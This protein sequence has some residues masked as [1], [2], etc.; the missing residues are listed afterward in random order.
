MG[1]GRGSIFGHGCSGGCSGHF[2][3]RGLGLFSR[4]HSCGGG[5]GCNGFTGYSV[6][7]SSWASGCY[8]SSCF[9]GCY[10]GAMVPPTGAVPPA[11]APDPMPGANPPAT[12][13]KAP[14]PGD[15]ATAPT[16]P[17]PK[18][19]DIPRDLP[20]IDPPTGTEISTVNPNQARVIVHLPVDAKL[21]VDQVACPISGPTRAFNTPALTPGA[22]YAYTLTVEMPGGAREDRRITMTAGGTVE[23]EFRGTGI[24]TVQR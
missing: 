6:G 20:K 3:G 14:A 16:Q 24:E 8:G 2:G 15:K 19:P 21:W 18:L 4:H 23:V 10:G 12:G 22:Q 1:S 11:T 13:D 5:Y 7:Y 17:Q 9:G